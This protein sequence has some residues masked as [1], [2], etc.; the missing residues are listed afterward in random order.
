[1]ISV[2]DVPVTFAGSADEQ[3][4]AERLLGLLRTHGRFM[5]DV[6]RIARWTKSMPRVEGAL[7]RVRAGC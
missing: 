5:S 3:A 4:F 7:L 2:G 6:A 1:M